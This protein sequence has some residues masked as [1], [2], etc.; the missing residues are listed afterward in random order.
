MRH[1]GP[2]PAPNSPGHPGSAAHPVVRTPYGPVRG[3]RRAT[4]VRFLGVPYARPPVGPLRFAAPVPPEPWREVRDA[5]VYGPTAQ[6]RASAG[7]TTIPEPVVPGPGILNLNVFTPDPSPGAGLPVL[8][9]IH[10]GGFCAGSPASPWYDGS[11]FSRDGVVVVTVGYRLGVEGFLSLPDAPDNRGVRDWIAALEWVREGIGAFGGDPAKVTVAG[12][13]AGGGA[14]LTLLATPS[15]R[16]LFRAGISA[17]G[18]VMRPQGRD[19]ARAVRRL[20]TDRTGLPAT[21]AAL[22]D[23]D[24][25]GLLAHQDRLTAPG[26]QRAALPMLALAPFA[27]GELVPE[28]VPEALVAGDAGGDVPLLL[29]CTAHEFAGL[30]QPHAT[31]EDVRLMLTAQGLDEEH[32]HRFLATY[33]GDGGRTPDGAPDGDG[34][35]DGDANSRTPDGTR[36]PTPG[37]VHSSTQGG[38]RS[39]AADGGHSLPDERTARGKHGGTGG[40]GPGDR[41][42]GTSETAYGRVSDGGYDRDPGTLLNRAVTDLTFRFPAVAIAGARARRGHATWLY[43][44]RWPSG[45][46]AFA[47]LAHHCTDLPFAFDL[48]AAEGAAPVLGTHPPQRLADAVHGAWTAFVRD[49]DPGWPR[50]T[51]RERA[52]RIWDDPP[53]TENDPLRPLREIWSPLLPAPTGLPER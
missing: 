52:T 53:R 15:A 29:G 49:L 12:Q 11:S 38:T 47:G 14:V 16:G 5:T 41:D 36:S 34:T 10:G 32:V 13:S 42:D 35:T 39:R 9:W 30:P 17:S 51:A 48:L 6:R 18:A 31:F 23:L 24:D 19:V 50:H 4:G 28:P 2:P 45:A 20:F 8:V 1:P 22:R 40:G 21:A 25:A 3:E 46:P 33:A 7:G 43:E 27:D 37:G 26:P 44:F